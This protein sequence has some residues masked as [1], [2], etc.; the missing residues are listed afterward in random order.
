MILDFD[1]VV[2]DH[3]D[4]NSQGYAFLA[5]N[6]SVFV[7]GSM[8]NTVSVTYYETGNAIQS[9]DQDSDGTFL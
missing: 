1:W 3:G 5:S 7:S 2:V 6:E 8:T 9:E 4:G